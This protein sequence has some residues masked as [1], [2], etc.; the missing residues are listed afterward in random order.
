MDW[1]EVTLPIHPL[2]GQ[3]LA[4]LRQSQDRDGQRRF[5]VAHPLGGTIRMPQ[6]WTDR[7]LRPA[8]PPQPPL[9]A[10]APAL[11][12]LAQAVAAARSQALDVTRYQGK[13]AAPSLR[14]SPV[15]HP[16]Q[17]PMVEASGEPPRAAHHS[18]GRTHPSDAARGS[19][20]E[21]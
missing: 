3:R 2:R 19:E 8:T 20:G 5:D 9:L 16:A 7:A 18:V 12:R 14:Y 10:Q 13:T 11:L 21:H 4:V 6:D 15:R 17:P 1:V